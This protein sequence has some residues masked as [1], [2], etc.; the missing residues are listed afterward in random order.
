MIGRRPPRDFLALGYK[1]GIVL[2]FVGI[3]ASA[4]Y[5]F[6][7]LW[8]AGT[9]PGPRSAIELVAI[10]VERRLLFLSTAIFVA[11][12]F[13]FLGFALFL[14]QA[15][16]D[17]DMDAA[18]GDYKLK[19]ARLSP[20]LFVILCSTVI[21]IVCATFKIEYQ[22]GP[23][24]AEGRPNP[25]DAELTPEIRQP[26]EPPPLRRTPPRNEAPASVPG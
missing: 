14:I 4:V 19:I 25:P 15:H 24:P 8:L 22:I 5:L 1:A 16:G 21:L 12:S 23:R 17:L 26:A 2:A 18:A 11:M 7:F 9:A 6:A 3:V 13:G 20:G 10:S